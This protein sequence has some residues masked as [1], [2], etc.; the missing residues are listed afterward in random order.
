MI[1]QLIGTIVEKNRDTVILLCNG[2]GFEVGV[3]DF[4]MR[5]LHLNTEAKLYTKMIVRE[6]HISMVG[7]FS[8][9]EKEMFELL[10]SVS[11][12]GP[13]VG[14]NI[15][16]SY[17]ITKVRSAIAGSNV[18]ML[19]KIPGIGKKTAERLILELKDK[20]GAAEILDMGDDAGT[21]AS[22]DD[23]L[24]VLLSLGFARNEAMQ[25]IKKLSSS[26]PDLKG[27][28]MIP[29]ALSLLSRV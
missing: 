29:K 25:A 17:E 9:E 26:Y 21:A 4:T 11:K 1:G 13:K 10:T 12:I 5:E 18:S 23:V 22:S 24:E 16:S 2:V 27:E 8:K 7:F 14:L 19:S 20:V 6:D 28:E 15:L 3:S